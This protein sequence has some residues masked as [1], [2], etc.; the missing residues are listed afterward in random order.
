[1]D[2]R[3]GGNQCVA[4]YLLVTAEWH[5]PRRESPENNTS[6]GQQRTE[7][8]E[9]SFFFFDMFDYIM[10]QYEVVARGR[11]E[12]EKVCC[13]ESTFATGS[14]KESVRLRNAACCLVDACHP[15]TQFGKGQEVASLAAAYFEN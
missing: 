6:I 2:E 1:M 8:A 14:G 12:N 5:L 11:G 15:A 10:Y 4:T 9:E 7:T 13:D 3:E